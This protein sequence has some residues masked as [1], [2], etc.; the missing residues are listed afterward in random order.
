MS[1]TFYHGTAVLAGGWTMRQVRLDERGVDAHGWVWGPGEPVFVVAPPD[2]DDTL[3]IR[4]PC[5][6]LA[7]W[8]VEREGWPPRSV[9]RYNWEYQT[10]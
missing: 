10:P 7:L 4:A 3:S 8:T 9:K 5:P 1:T 6:I 2:V